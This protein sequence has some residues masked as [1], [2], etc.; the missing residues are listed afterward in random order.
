QWFIAGCLLLKMTL[1]KKN[2]ASFVNFSFMNSFFSF[3]HHSL[4]FSFA[5]F[6][7]SRQRKEERIK[8]KSKAD[9]A[10]ASSAIYAKPIFCDLFV[11]NLI[12]VYYLQ[13]QNF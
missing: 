7:V 8:N 6:F 11:N 3:F 1:A 10:S 13:T 9:V 2:S 4:D 5:S 12:S